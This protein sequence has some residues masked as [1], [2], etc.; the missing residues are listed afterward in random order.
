MSVFKEL[1]QN[2]DDAGATEIK[3]ILDTR[4]F[5]ANKAYERLQGPALCCWHNSIFKESD[6]EGIISLGKSYFFFLFYMILLSLCLKFRY[7]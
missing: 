2:A 6:F 5:K 4:D 1:V 7:G 3:F